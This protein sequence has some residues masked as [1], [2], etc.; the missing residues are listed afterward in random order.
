LRMEM[1]LPLQ[2]IAGACDVASD[3]ASWCGIIST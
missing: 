3:I 1:L 2:K